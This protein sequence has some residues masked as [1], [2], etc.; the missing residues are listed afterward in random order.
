M[1]S[2][3]SIAP[4]FLIPLIPLFTCPCF[5]LQSSEYCSALM[6]APCCLLNSHPPPPPA[7]HPPSSTL[8]VTKAPPQQTQRNFSAQLCVYLSWPS[9]RQPS[10]EFTIGGHG[11]NHGWQYS[12]TVT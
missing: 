12:A 11:L 2:S 1:L 4:C 10:L 8:M 6:G 7:H 3:L 5:A 9:V